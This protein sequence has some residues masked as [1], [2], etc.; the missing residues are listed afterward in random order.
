MA[1]RKIFC[2]ECGQET[3]V[4]DEKAFCFCLQCGN[5][6]LIHSGQTDTEINKDGGSVE[7]RADEIEKKLEEAA[8]YYQLSREKGEA[9]NYSSDPVYYLKAQDILVDLSQ[10]Y[11]EDYRIWWELCKPVDFYDAASG[12][13]IY[14]QYRINEDYFGRALDKA[15][16]NEKR[17]L[18]DEH[19]RY[20]DEKKIC[21]EKAVEKRREEEERKRR[22]DAARQEEER[23]RQEEIRNIEIARQQEQMR[24]KQK[25]I[26]KR[27]ENMQK[28]AALSVSM[29]QELKDKDYH[30]IDNSFF[31][32]QGENNQTII[33][34]FKNVS[35]VMYLMAFHID[36]NKGNT[37]YRDQSISIKFDG[38]GHG[39]KFD[40]KPVRIKGMLPQQSDLFISNDGMGGLTVNGLELHNDIDY[41]V[42]IMKNAKKPLLAF[43]KYFL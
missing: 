22:E 32:F 18:I 3:Q 15:G 31:N 1:L 20:A 16:L 27:Q 10:I 26:Q 30:A 33:G 5:K 23:K 4:N 6:I 9:A 2:P 29:W 7:G 21:M 41:V 12:N 25:E 19:D 11:P 28:G 24:L 37:V 36:G 40:N 43:T 38:S 17:R 13:D 34:I 14:G 42:S 35:N 8:F 39:L